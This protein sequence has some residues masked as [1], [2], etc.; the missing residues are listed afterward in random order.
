VKKSIA[1]KNALLQN[2]EE[3]NRDYQLIIKAYQEFAEYERKRS[4]DQYNLDFEPKEGT[5]TQEEQS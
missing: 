1:E 5:E 2:L 3:Q 4:D